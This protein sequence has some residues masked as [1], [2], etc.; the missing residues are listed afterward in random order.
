MIDT[1]F[2][3]EFA[4]LFTPPLAPVD[5]H[6]SLDPAAFQRRHD[7]PRRPV[8]VQDA[9][10]WPALTR[11]RDPDYLAT[12]GAPATVYTRRFDPEGV[13]RRD[14]QE[15]TFADVVRRLWKDPP[16]DLYLTQLLIR[17]S[18]GLA[19]AF[20]RDVH[21]GQVPEL[22]GDVRCPAYWRED[23]IAECGLWMGPGHQFTGLHFD[24]HDNMLVQVMGTKRVLLFPHGE[25][26]RLMPSISNTAIPF[27][28]LE[29]RR[30][31]DP[32]RRRA[33][34]YEVVIEPGDM[35]YIPAGYWHEVYGGPG[36]NLSVN[37]WMLR[38]RAGDFVRL[39][40][41]HA[42]RRTGFRKPWPV[43][44]ATLAVCLCL[45]VAR[46][47]GYLARGAP[48]VRIGATSYV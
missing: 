42:R 29:S 4:P 10:D 13:E 48:P 16:E 20:G 21:P 19:G 6:A 41:Y 33:R 32:R 18:G 14:L 22:W 44:A 2:G 11:W 43:Y 15:T 35:L 40:R 9:R 24:E 36:R 46:A 28:P 31:D 38:P 30:F 12:V 26:P 25:A 1:G 47:L 8:V 7:R 5:R 34:G 23:D 39:L 27:S 17:R 3:T 37:F 45:G